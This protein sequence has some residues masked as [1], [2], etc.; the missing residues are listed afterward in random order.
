MCKFGCSVCSN[1]V[2]FL[3]SE[4]LDMRPDGPFSMD[5]ET[6]PPEPFDYQ[7]P[8]NNKDRPRSKISF[9]DHLVD[10]NDKF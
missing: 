10:N 9:R 8:M 6:P 2:S 7:T 1:I 4:E 3:L 5:I